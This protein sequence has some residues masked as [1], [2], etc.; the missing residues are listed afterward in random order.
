MSKIGNTTFTDGSGLTLPYNLNSVQTALFGVIL[1]CS[2]VTNN[3]TLELGDVNTGRTMLKLE[4]PNAEKSK[5]YDFSLAPITFPRGL[6][7][8]SIADAEVTMITG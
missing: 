8:K 7:L 6:Q 5:H 4:L 3:A 2:H 1:T